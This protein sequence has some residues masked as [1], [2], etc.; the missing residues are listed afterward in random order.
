MADA[1]M[2]LDFLVAQVL[3]KRY[4]AVI[5]FATADDAATAAALIRKA[6]TARKA[7]P[8]KKPASRKKK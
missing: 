5:G 7:A 3:S 1:G 4:T 8:A 2:N 6:S